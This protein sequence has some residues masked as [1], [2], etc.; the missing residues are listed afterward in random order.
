M[1]PNTCL[2]NLLHFTTMP[3][4]P[5]TRCSILQRPK[6]KYYKSY[7]TLHDSLRYGR[8]YENRALE[9]MS[10]YLGEEIATVKVV[11]LN[12]VRGAPDGIVPSDGS[13]VEV[14]CPIS[15]LHV[16]GS[17][18]DHYK[19]HP[20][21]LVSPDCRLNTHCNEQARSYY[22]QCQCYLL[23]RP[24]SPLLHLGIW[25]PRARPQLLVIDILP[26]DVWRSSHTRHGA[27]EECKECKKEEETSQRH[28]KQDPLHMA[29]EGDDGEE[30]VNCHNRSPE[31]EESAE[32]ETKERR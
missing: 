22:H 31:E 13:L 8:L 14:K 20:G 17:L 23:Q 29:Q 21:A 5:T 6:S 4:Q 3:L 26:D 27:E 30:V 10:E 18:I 7:F 9:C 11:T 28:G 25:A 24:S 12:G 19:K 16:R 32:E 2:F 1:C 15:L